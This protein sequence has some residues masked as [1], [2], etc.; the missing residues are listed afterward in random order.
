VLPAFLAERRWFGEK[1]E[2]KAVRCDSSCI[3]HSIATKDRFLIAVIDVS[4]GGNTSS[5]LFR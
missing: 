2:R 5:Y 4:A 1:S 3:F